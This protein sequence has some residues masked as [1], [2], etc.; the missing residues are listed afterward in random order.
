M[1]SALFLILFLMGDIAFAD[2]VKKDE[3]WQ[4]TQLTDEV[5]QKIQK[6]QYN[7]K[8]CVVDDMRKPE[9]A[10][11]ESRNATD[12]IIR[13]CEP[14]L[15]EIRKVYLDAEVPGVVADRHLKKMRIQVTRNVLQ[16]LMYAEAQKKAGIPQ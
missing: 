8:K 13:D 7:Y 3:E 2:E 5:I 14:V 15:A 6:A 9:N 10:K 11:L 4:E 1:K 16:E 12:V